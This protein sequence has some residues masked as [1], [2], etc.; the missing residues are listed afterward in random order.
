MR[1]R[2]NKN[3]Y[4]GSKM[5]VNYNGRSSDLFSSL[6]LLIPKHIGTMV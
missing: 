6:N 4:P 5:F 2:S 3:F 1:T